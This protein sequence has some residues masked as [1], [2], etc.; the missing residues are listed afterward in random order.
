MADYLTVQEAAEL[1]GK[2]VSTIRNLIKEH[3]EDGDNITKRGKKVYLLKRVFL[4]E[5]Y[6][7]EDAGEV[8]S[9]LISELRDRIAHLER[10]NERLTSLLEGEQQKEL[11]QLKAQ[12]ARMGYLELPPGQDAE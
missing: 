2:S 7:I 3:G 10:Q 8:E 5:R 6:G 1:T 12:L 9:A 11:A 4:E